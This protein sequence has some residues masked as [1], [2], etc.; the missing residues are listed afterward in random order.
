MEKEWVKLQVAWFFRQSFNSPFDTLANSL[1]EALSLT[2]N[3]IVTIVPIPGEAPDEIPRLLMNDSADSGVVIKVSRMR[4]DLVISSEIATITPE[5][6]VSHAQSL[7]N[8]LPVAVGRFGFVKSWFVPMSSEQ[9]K[10]R[11]LNDTYRSRN[12]SEVSVRVNEPILMQ[13]IQCNNLESIQPSRRQDA[14]GSEVAGILV[15]RDL[16]TPTTLPNALAQSQIRDLITDFDT[17]AN[18]SLFGVFE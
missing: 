8:L 14:D 17:Q 11:L 9:L 4:L 7:N 18:T 12:F 5:Q 10:S 3:T 2:D 16:N 1:R 6:A 13:H 15:E